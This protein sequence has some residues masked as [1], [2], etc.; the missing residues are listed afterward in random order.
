MQATNRTLSREAVAS[1]RASLRAKLKTLRQ[2]LAC[3]QPELAEAIGVPYS[4]VNLIENR[5]GTCNVDRAE[6]VVKKAYEQFGAPYEDVTAMEQM[7]LPALTRTTTPSASP[8]PAEVDPELF[9]RGAT[10][11]ETARRIRMFKE[12]FGLKP[13]E[14]AHLFGLSGGHEYIL[15]TGRETSGLDTR[16]KVLAIID[17]ETS[18]RRGTSSTTPSTATTTA[19]ALP[20][21]AGNTAPAP[22]ANT[23]NTQAKALADTVVS[24]A[25][26]VRNQLGLAGAINFDFKTRHI[27]SQLPDGTILVVKES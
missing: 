13:A 25:T 2:K 23:V 14:L 15:R 18:K 16:K 26:L 27:F 17:R 9:S 21:T 11:S 10:R 7:T 19:P 6:A 1:K 5:S 4:Y 20:V 24:P 8:G 12:E 22:E 3:T